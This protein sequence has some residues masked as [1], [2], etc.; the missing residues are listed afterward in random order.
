VKTA[1][2]QRPRRRGAAG[3]R[4]ASRARTRAGCGFFE[5]C[6]G[7]AAGKPRAALTGHLAGKPARWSAGARGGN[8]RSHAGTRCNS[9]GAGARSKPSRWG[10]NHEDGTR[11]VGWHRP[12]EGEATLREWTRAGDVGKAPSERA[13][14]L[15]DEATRHGGGSAAAGPHLARDAGDLRRRSREIIDPAGRWPRSDA[16]RS[17]S[18]FTRRRGVSCADRPGDGTA[19]AV[20]SS[21]RAR[22]RADPVSP[23][24]SGRFRQRGGVREHG[25]LRKA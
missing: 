20:R 9:L 12:A 2:G 7:N 11:R 21:A 10:S 15:G 13:V 19:S 24:G 16:R 18:R 25:P 8:Q 17:P 5:G 1:R 6:E 14:C 23:P 3:P 22:T 4:L